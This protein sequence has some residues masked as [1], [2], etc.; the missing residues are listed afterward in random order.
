M[1]VFETPILF[2]VFN[3]PDETARVFESIRSRRPT[4]LF[5]A[6]D[7]ARA[8]RPGEAEVVRRTREIATA[9]DWPCEVKTLF[10]TENLGCGRA[11]SEAITWF[12]TE[13]EAG[14]ILE[15][16]CLPHP[17][18]YTFCADL[19]VRYRDEPRI[20]TIGGTHFLPEDLPHARSHYASKYF[21]MW[22]WASWRRSWAGYDL[23]LGKQSDAEWE[24]LIARVHPNPTEAGY[25][26]EI[27]RS[28]KGGTIDTWDFQVFFSTWQA[29]AGHL[30]PGR[31]LVSNIGYGPAATHTNFQSPMANLPTFPVKVGPEPVSLTPDPAVDNLIF[32]LRFLESMNQTWWVEQVLKPELKLGQT[33][34]QLAQSERRI[35]ELERE[36]A[37]KRR[38]L[39]AA[40]RALARQ[41]VG[42]TP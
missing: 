28:L 4:R 17:D 33:R 6:A 29:G 3:R 36:A 23:T 24:A 12:F 40:T 19:L 38:Q 9:V 39:L 18:F 11:V 34:L 10:R 22:G 35:R 2:L 32:Y 16:D 15:D 13:V 1:A 42:A 25:W 37:D 26:R 27:Y 21:Q 8:D 30:M 31:N 5:V 14:I 7:G 41:S 20:A